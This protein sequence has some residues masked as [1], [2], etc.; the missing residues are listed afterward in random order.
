[1]IVEWLILSCSILLDTFPDLISYDLF[2][3]FMSKPT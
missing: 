2:S 1:L 3:R